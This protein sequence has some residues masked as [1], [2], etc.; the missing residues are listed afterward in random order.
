MVL[1][2]KEPKSPRPNRK[3]NIM[4]KG[5][6]ETLLDKS[7]KQKHGSFIAKRGSAV[8]MKKGDKVNITIE[9]MDRGYI[10]R[11]K[12]D[13]ELIEV[14][15]D[16]L[17][18]GCRVLLMDVE[19]IKLKGYFDYRDDVYEGQM[20]FFHHKEKKNDFFD[21]MEEFLVKKDLLNKEVEVTIKVLED[22]NE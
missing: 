19:E 20:L 2:R 3:N 21:F 4:S 9:K 16:E 12:T 13:D 22:D 15:N 11:A 5:K 17:E 10:F 7:R 1:M 6:L 14:S 8:N 18:K